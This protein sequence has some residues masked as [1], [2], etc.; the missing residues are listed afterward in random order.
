MQNLCRFQCFPCSK[1]MISRGLGFKE[2][3]K[4]CILEVAQ[5]V[6]MSDGDGDGDGNGDANGDGDISL[7]M[8]DAKGMANECD[9]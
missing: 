5:R 4:M 1:F 7:Q 2:T 6:F 3:M 9:V 8:T